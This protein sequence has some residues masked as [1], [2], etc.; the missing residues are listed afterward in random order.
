LCI[1]NL[2]T[3]KDCAA[4]LS[5]NSSLDKTVIHAVD[6]MGR[7]ITP[8]PNVPFILIYEDGTREKKMEIEK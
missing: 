6:F 4:G 5:E 7:E 3:G 8:E 2:T 1:Y